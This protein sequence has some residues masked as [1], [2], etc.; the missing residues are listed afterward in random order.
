M[1]LP[2][3]GAALPLLLLITW[4]VLP[5]SSL[6]STISYGDFLG[7]SV[8]FLDVTESSEHGG[9]P[10]FGAPSVAGDSLIF[11]P[12]Q[13]SVSHVGGGLPT[14]AHSVLS[15]TL[16][17]GAGVLGSVTVTETG[18]FAMGGAPGGAAVD[19]KVKLR[20]LADGLD[21]LV[22][23]VI[24]PAATFALPIT[25]GTWTAQATFDFTGLGLKTAEIVLTDYLE[26]RSVFHTHASVWKDE[27]VVSYVP[28][29]GTLVLGMLGLAGLAVLGRRR[30]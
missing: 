4:L 1:R 28:E 20:V 8:A 30:E 12:D 24:S 19:I 27:V 29:P 6:A 16:D 15:L 3:R 14:F 22:P 9:L 26:A 2:Y 21:V 25:G 23:V 13:F 10:R 5:A 17:A 11:L 7:S 18:G